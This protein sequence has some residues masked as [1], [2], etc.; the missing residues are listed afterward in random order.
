MVVPSVYCIIVCHP[1]TRDP[2]P[3]VSSKAISEEMSAAKEGA[4][5]SD[6]DSESQPPRHDLA[7]EGAADLCGQLDR[8]GLPCKVR[9]ALSGSGKAPKSKRQL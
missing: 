4:S 5:D 3:A 8:Q 1:G 6:S 2:L 7:G 9:S